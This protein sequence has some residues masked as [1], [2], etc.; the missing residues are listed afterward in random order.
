[1]PAL[2]IVLSLGS[3]GKKIVAGLDLGISIEEEG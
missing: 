3:G 2:R 1:L